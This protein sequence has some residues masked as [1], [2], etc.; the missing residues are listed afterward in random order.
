MPKG[1]PSLN[2]VEAL[3]RLQAVDLEVLK[4]TKGIESAERDLADLAARIEK[5]RTLVARAKTELQAAQAKVRAGE[6]EVAEA[7]GKRKKLDERL[8]VAD[9]PKTLSAAEAEIAKLEATVVALEE[10]V[11]ALME[12]E[13]EAKKLLDTAEK[14]LQN[15]EAKRRQVE[16]GLP[17]RRSELQARIGELDAERARWRD[18]IEPADLERYDRLAKKLPPPV[19]VEVEEACTGCDAIFTESFRSGLMH[20]QDRVHLCPT[21]GR[22]L[23]YVGAVSL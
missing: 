14:G 5:T 22:I 8:R 4:G 10:G 7:R 11:L 12:A 3:R 15:L 16:G 23:V 1:W 17:A 19:V 6:G 2:S 18:R 13:E 21:C 9:S 20:S